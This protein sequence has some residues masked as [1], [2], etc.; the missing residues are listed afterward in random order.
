MNIKCH[1]IKL[2]GYPGPP[3]N[4]GLQGAR[5]LP[6]PPRQAG[7]MGATGL[8]GPDGSPGIE[9]YKCYGHIFYVLCVEY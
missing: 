9:H 2:L 4:T 8:N 3:G 1:T 7:D 5:G 6:G